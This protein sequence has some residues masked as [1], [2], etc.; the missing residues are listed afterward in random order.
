MGVLFYVGQLEKIP[1]KGDIEQRSEGIN[2]ANCD[3]IR[4]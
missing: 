1:R 2:E 3:Y 4:K